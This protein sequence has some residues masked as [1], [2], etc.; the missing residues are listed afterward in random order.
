MISMFPL[1]G[2]RAKIFS[3]QRLV[4]RIGTEGCWESRGEVEKYRYELFEWSRAGWNTPA[5][6]FSADANSHFY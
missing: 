5:H 3:F 4:G 6:A 1:C 2:E